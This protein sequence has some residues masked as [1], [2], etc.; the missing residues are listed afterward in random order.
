M[1]YSYPVVI[2]T[3]VLMFICATISP[4]TYSPLTYAAEHNNGRSGVSSASMKT[5]QQAN[6]I[7][8]TWQ[9][10]SGRYLN[11]QQQWVDYASLNLS[12][13]KIIAASHFSFTTVQ[14]T[15]TGPKFWAAGTGTYQLTN[16]T[17]TEQPSLNSFGAVVGQ[18]FVFEYQLKNNQ[19]HTQRVE[20]GDLQEVEVWQRL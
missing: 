19:L 4:L 5:E 18:E 16:T 8:G 9:L 14:Q 13:I 3:S 6:P 15:A 11:E 7:Q 20:N 10:V 2:A 1:L 17:Y 12:A